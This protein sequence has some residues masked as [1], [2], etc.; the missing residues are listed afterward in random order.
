[1]KRLNGLVFGLILAFLAGPVWA[2]G[3]ITITSPE[4]G[5]MLAMSGNKLTFNVTL[6][7]NGNHVHIYV[8]DQNP[9]VY[10]DVAHCPC[11]IDLPMLSSGKHMVAIK[12]A[13]VSHALTGVEGSVSFTVK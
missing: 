13:T 10:R 4:N 11:T 6:S 2:A 9:I 5:A 8:D 7:P 12:E 3:S 1:M